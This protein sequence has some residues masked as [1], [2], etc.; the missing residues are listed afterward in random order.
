MSV[1]PIVRVE[2]SLDF[3]IETI[4]NDY[5]VSNLTDFR[6]LDPMQGDSLFSES[7]LAS[8]DRIKKRL[9]GERHSALR[10]NGAGTDP[11]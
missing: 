2:E 7:L 1:A 5:I 8:L 11:Q 3:R 10:D 6:R 4:L 9:G